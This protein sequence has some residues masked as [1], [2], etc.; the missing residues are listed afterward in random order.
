MDERDWGGLSFSLFL[1]D[2]STDVAIGMN[3]KQGLTCDVLSDSPGYVVI[4][5]LGQS[6][7]VQSGTFLVDLSV[8]LND[9][10]RDAGLTNPHAGSADVLSVTSAEQNTVCGTD[11]NGDEVGISYA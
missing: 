3:E 9:M 10:A 8:S 5:F 6:V 11:G 4:E 1:E 7:R 2:S